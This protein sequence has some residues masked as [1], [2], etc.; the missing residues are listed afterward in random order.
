VSWKNINLKIKCCH[1]NNIIYIY[2][3]FLYRKIYPAERGN[4]LAYA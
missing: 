4:I 2:K 1:L 3:L